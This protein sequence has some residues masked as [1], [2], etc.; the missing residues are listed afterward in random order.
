MNTSTV[1]AENDASLGGVVSTSLPF[2][3]AL[4][5]V[6]PLPLALGLPEDCL[7]GF[8]STQVGLK[9]M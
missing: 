5:G 7:R 6:A 2:E 8:I 4:L 3:D 1:N 9:A